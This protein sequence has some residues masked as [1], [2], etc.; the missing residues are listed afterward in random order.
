LQFDDGSSGVIAYLSEGDGSLGKERI[1]IFGEGKT[2]VI[3]DFRSGRLYTG[4]R[5][6]KETLRRPDKGQAEETRVACE[7]VAEGKAA[8]ITLRELE[9]TTRATFRI[10][11]SLRTGQ[12]VP[13]IRRTTD[14]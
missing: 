12:P 11:D 1:E 10:R 13:V 6:K 8:P 14:D 4:G 5:D 9:A 7:V 2:F 3:E